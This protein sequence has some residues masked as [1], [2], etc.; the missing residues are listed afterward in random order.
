[1]QLA[2]SL[3]DAA[4]AVTTRLFRVPGLAVDAK[5]DASPVTIADREAEDVMRSLIGAAAPAH[6]VF[7]EE[8]GL[9]L[10]AGGSA[11]WLWVLDP[12]DGTKSFITGAKC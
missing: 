4:A 12:I 1:M 6:A 3:A 11:E 10:G 7:G 8:H 9:T 2:L 5:S